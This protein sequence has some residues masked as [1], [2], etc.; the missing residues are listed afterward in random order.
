VAYH[1][2]SI[3]FTSSED[4]GWTEDYWY[5]GALT[6]LAIDTAVQELAAARAFLLSADCRMVRART[7]T[8][9]KRFVNITN[10]SQISS[11][12]GQ[13][14]GTVNDPND[15]VIVEFTNDLVGFNRIFMR[16]LPDALVVANNFQ[17]D[18]AWIFNFQAYEAILLAGN[19]GVHSVLGNP[20]PTFN[21]KSA[22]R[23]FPKGINLQV[24]AGSPINLG[25]QI[26]IAGSSIYGYNGV[27]NVVQSLGVVGGN[28]AWLLGGAQPPADSSVSDVIRVTPLLPAEGLITGVAYLQYTQRKAG[29]PF[30]LRRGRART[31]LSLRP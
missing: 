7:E 15:A 21:A 12:Q 28:D 5:T 4:Y 23:G 2:C 31:Q 19:W 26:R 24:P 9:N 20:Q 6:S 29:R 14:A 22:T 1:R 16:G 11:Y 25:Q 8:S 13:I 10:L 27:K 17:P 3:F 30:G 18:T